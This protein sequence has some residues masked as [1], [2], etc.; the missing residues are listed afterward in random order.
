MRCAGARQVIGIDLIS[1]RL[2]ISAQC[3]IDTQINFTQTEVTEE[4]KHLTVD[5]GCQSWLSHR[6]PT[7]G[8]PALKAAAQLG[9]V[10]LLGS[11]RA[12]PSPTSTPTCTEPAF[13]SSVP[14]PAAKPM[15]LNTMKLI[16]ND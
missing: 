5:T 1:S 13:R 9:E 8:P 16:P 14:T 3:G 7:T 11:P 12:T 10:I 2:A 15:S 4:I 6:H